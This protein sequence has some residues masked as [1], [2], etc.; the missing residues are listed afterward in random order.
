M[1]KKRKQG[2]SRALQLAV[3]GGILLVVQ[4]LVWS[5]FLSGK[6]A[7]PPAEAIADAV[8]KLDDPRKR[9]RMQIH[10]AIK[11]FKS[12][13][14]KLP[15]TLQELVPVYLKEVPL[16]VQTGKA[17]EYK[18]VDGQIFVGTPDRP[19]SATGGTTDDKAKK[20]SALPELS[21]ELLEALDQ[22]LSKTTPIYNAKG[23]RDPFTPF[24]ARG[25]ETKCDRKQPL[26]CWEVAQL[27][28]GG[29]I[30]LPGGYLATVEDPSNR[31]Y[32]IKKGMKVG[33]NG[34][35]VVE[36]TQDKLVVMEELVDFTGKKERVNIELKLRT[37]EDE[38]DSFGLTI[39]E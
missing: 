39:K 1:A 26:T 29:V 27:R 21:P 14:G 38:T 16:D 25:P 24:N 8:A 10:L 6:A 37:K 20:S 23:K 30:K 19:K 5:L 36:V 31:S 2:P 12:E 35:T 28:L 32:R 34:G 17:W 15:I 18:V 7:K 4:L 22:D 11:T 3:I 9:D 13:Q 33:K